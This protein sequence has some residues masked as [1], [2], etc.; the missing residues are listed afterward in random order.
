MRLPLIKHTLD[1]VEQN[2]EDWIKEAIEVLEHI[3]E[4]PGIK[5]QEMDVIGELLSNLY[6]TLEV[7]QAIKDG[8]DKKSA[9]NAFMKR[10]VGSID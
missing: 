1:F 7:S 8:V 6:G 9:L 2:D 10:V 3:S 4:A 5:D